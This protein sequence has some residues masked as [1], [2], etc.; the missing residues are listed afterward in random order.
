VSRASGGEGGDPHDPSPER[1]LG[2]CRTQRRGKQRRL[3]RLIGQPLLRPFAQTSPICPLQIASH[4]RARQ[5]RPDAIAVRFSPKSAL[6][7]Q[8][9]LIR[10][11]SD[12]DIGI[13]TP[14][15]RARKYC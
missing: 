1:S 9:S 4:R 13:V 5:A 14:R 15:K 3:K 8:T 2:L 7:L 11:I 12:L 6:S 10:R